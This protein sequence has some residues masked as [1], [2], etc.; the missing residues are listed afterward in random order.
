MAHNPA[1]EADNHASPVV[2]PLPPLVYRFGRSRHRDPKVEFITG[3]W[4][5]VS[6]GLHFQSDGLW[7]GCV[8]SFQVGRKISPNPS[9]PEKYLQ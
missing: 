2:F 8:E 7:I 4:L 1:I 9:R 3:L 6:F 5:R